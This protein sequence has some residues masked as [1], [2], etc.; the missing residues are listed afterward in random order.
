MPERGRRHP[1]RFRR[2]SLISITTSTLRS[3]PRAWLPARAL[4][5]CRQFRGAARK[6]EP[7]SAARHGR[8]GCGR[9]SCLG[10]SQY[11]LA[12]RYQCFQHPGS[13]RHYRRSHGRSAQYHRADR[14]LEYRW[15]RFR[16]RHPGNQTTDQPSRTTGCPV[17]DHSG[18]ARLWRPQS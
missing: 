9:H 14:S 6:R 16:S 17:V 8:R 18:S 3:T 4:Q 7:H 12:L 15:S 10:Q 13:R 1:T 2:Q 11:R 5:H